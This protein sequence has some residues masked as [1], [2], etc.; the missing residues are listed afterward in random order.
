MDWKGKSSRSPL[1]LERSVSQGIVSLRNRSIEG[2]LFIQTT[3]QINPGNSGG[4]LMNL[5]GEVVG[6]NDMKFIGFGVE[7]M[8][9]AIPSGVLKDFLKNRDAFAF[10]P[11]NPNAGFRYNEPPKPDAPKKEEA[12]KKDA[13]PPKAPAPSRPVPAPA[14]PAGNPK[15]PEKKGPP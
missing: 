14:P 5:R 3:A 12:P 6:V 4:P 11:K 1:G 13:S 8:G 15:P 10:D 9:F 2:R 7:G